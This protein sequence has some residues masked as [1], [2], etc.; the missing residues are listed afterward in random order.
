MREM[1]ESNSR[2]RLYEKRGETSVFIDVEIDDKGDIILSGQDL[3]KAPM[4]FWGDSDYEYWTI[5][6]R[7]QKDLL[8][9]SLIKEKFGGNVKAFSNFKEYLIK[10]GIP[11]EF[12]SYA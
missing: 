4:E 10:E 6:K 2:F 12:G 1:N 8:L 7:D 3:G 9:L 11:Y 5:V